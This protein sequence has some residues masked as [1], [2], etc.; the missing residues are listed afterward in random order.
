[1]HGMPRRR[2]SRERK[3]VGAENPGRLDTGSKLRI[4]GEGDA[5]GKGGPSGD[6]Y[7]VLSVQDHEFFER[8]DHDLYCHIPITYPQAALGA[9]IK[10]PTLER[11]EEKLSIPAGT[12]TGSTFRVKGR[13]ISKRGGSAR[14]DLYVTVGI[15]V[16]TKL[17]RDQKDLL[18]QLASTIEIENKPIKKKILERVKEIL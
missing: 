7:V 17:S 5:G 11:E 14:G 15:T 12:Q 8:R 13:G 1:M 16:P 10:V 9:Q 3:N 6:L 18:S 4:S 2:P